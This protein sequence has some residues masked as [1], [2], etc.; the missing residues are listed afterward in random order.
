M[1]GPPTQ[2][3]GSSM[4]VQRAP[5]DRDPSGAASASASVGSVP[6]FPGM[7]MASSRPR[8]QVPHPPT[9]FLLGRR[10]RG[11]ST[12]AEPVFRRTAFRESLAMV[13]EVG[14]PSEAAK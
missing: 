4:P 10:P 13:P 9:L 2:G 14:P 6:A 1:P 5:G 12:P 3:R 8:R 11:A 7:V